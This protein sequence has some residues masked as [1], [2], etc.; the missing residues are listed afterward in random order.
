M[1]MRRNRSMTSNTPTAATRALSLCALLASAALASDTAGVKKALEPYVSRLEIPG[2]VS[3]LIDGDREEWVADG[4]SDV[5]TRKPI[6]K[7]SLFRICS[8]TKGIVG[9]AAAKLVVEGKLS[10]DE[11]VSKYLPEFA[12]LERV[13]ETNG[14]KTL[15]P[16]KNVLTV[17][18]CLSHTGGFPFETK[19]SSALGWTGAP[20]R[21]AAAAGAATPLLFEPG[22]SW[23]YSN[24]GLDVA[25]AIVEAATG[26]KIE[27]H[28]KRVF[29]GPLGMKDTTFRPTSEQLKRLVSMYYVETNKTCR[30]MPKYRPLREPYD[31]PNRWPSCGAGLFST[32]RDLLEFYRMLAFG[33]VSRDGRRIMPEKAVTGLLAV[34][35]TPQGVKTAY[36]LGMF[37]EGEWFGHDGALKTAALLNPKRHAV[38]LWMMQCEYPGRINRWHQY[39]VWRPV[40]NR[41]FEQT[42]GR[43]SNGETP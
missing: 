23:K 12:K 2:Y 11:P 34:K 18:D 33:G 14:V 24:A 41:F 43:G 1:T 36:S 30:P 13:V 10:L 20:L 27:D 6:T 22:T 32:P 15:V 19:V 25:G 8:Q 9:A 3:V 37:V 29:F 16:V 21:V 28:L 40:V 7:D 38:W 39:K 26:E 31:S 4:W 5:A 42:T 35:Q 17:R